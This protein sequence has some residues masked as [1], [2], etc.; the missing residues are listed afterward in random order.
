PLGEPAIDRRQQRMRLPAPPLLAPQPRQANG[1]PQ[2]MAFR[3]SV[4]AE[5]GHT[6]IGVGTNCLPPNT[7][8]SMTASF[9][10]VSQ[11]ECNSVHQTTKIATPVAMAISSTVAG[12]TQS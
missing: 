11:F 5:R 4:K 3:L 10:V 2:L 12:Q 1:G 6:K 8:E 7:S 9:V